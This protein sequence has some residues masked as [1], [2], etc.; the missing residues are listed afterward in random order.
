MTLR[1]SQ[2]VPPVPLIVAEA[3]G[4]L[5]R[6][7]VDARRTTGSP[8]Q[9]AGLLAGDIDLAVTAIDNLFAWVPAGADVQLV[10]Q[11]EST[12]AL[13]IF[14]IGGPSSLA[15]LTGRRFGVDAAGNGFALAARW[16]LES[17]GVGG[18]DYAEVGGVRERLGALLD[19]VVDA[20]LLGPPFDATAVESGAVLL[21]RVPEMLP[22]FPGQGLVA[23]ADACG[24]EDVAAYLDALHEAT[25]ISNR[26]EDAEGIDMLVAA[27]F[28]KAA[29][30]AWATR[31]RTLR[32][33]APGLDVITRVRA[34][35]G[36]LPPGVRLADLCVPGILQE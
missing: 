1:Q 32:V 17:A 29:A 18:V 24:S 4:L 15:Q 11:M 19:G 2:F 28:G 20:T 8:H 6:V 3:N 30:S 7:D 14:A 33:P 13:G 21:G 25:T 16:L 26:I 31:P 27:G 9:L 35:L 10:A 22:G 5:D 34:D 12:T 23:R 36:M